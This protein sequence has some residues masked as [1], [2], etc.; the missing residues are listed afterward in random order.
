MATTSSGVPD[1]SSAQPRPQLADRFQ[2]GLVPL[3]VAGPAPGADEL[4]QRGEVGQLLPVRVG[5]VH[6]RRGGLQGH[7]RVMSKKHV[8]SCTASASNVMT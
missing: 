2:L 5:G 6:Q 1:H 8:D 3:T 4:V 7:L